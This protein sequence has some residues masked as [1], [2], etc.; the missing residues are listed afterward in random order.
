M[1]EIAHDRST[2]EKDFDVVYRKA[3]WLGPAAERPSAEYVSDLTETP[4]V[5]EES[6]DAA[7]APSLPTERRARLQYL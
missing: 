1:W 5:A 7:R 3:L 4:F 2:Y 6:T